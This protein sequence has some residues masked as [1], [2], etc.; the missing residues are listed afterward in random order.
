[1]GSGGGARTGAPN[2]TPTPASQRSHPARTKSHFPTNS[3]S[4]AAG[5]VINHRERAQRGKGGGWARG[6]R[7]RGRRELQAQMQARRGGGWRRSA[8]GGGTRGRRTNRKGG[9]EIKRQRVEKAR[10]KEGQRRGEEV[11]RKQGK[12]EKEKRV[13]DESGRWGREGGMK[14]NT[15]RKCIQRSP[16][17]SGQEA[18]HRNEGGEQSR[19]VSSF[20]SC[21]LHCWGTCGLTPHLCPR[22]LLQVDR[23]WMEVKWGPP[24]PLC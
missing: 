22:C 9:K 19:P 15:R 4:E 1:M 18:D 24:S 17:M 6:G 13:K 11:E 5:R 8:W 2:P 12:L 3:L 20:T 21:V 23:H 14:L 10:E 7:G 16:E